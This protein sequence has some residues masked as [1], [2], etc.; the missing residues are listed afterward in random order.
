MM[1]MGGGA[2]EVT[3]KVVKFSKIATMDFK[4]YI[5]GLNK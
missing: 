5:I 1:K 2:S 3:S 4:V